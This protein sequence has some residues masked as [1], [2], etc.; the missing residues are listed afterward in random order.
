MP[1]AVVSLAAAA[2]AIGAEAKPPAN[3]AV[4]LSDRILA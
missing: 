1:G 2:A 4:R 3:A